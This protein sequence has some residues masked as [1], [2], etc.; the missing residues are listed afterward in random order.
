MDKTRAHSVSVERSTGEAADPTQKD[1]GRGIS[2]CLTVSELVTVLQL[3]GGI[4]STSE[5]YDD[6][7][8]L[9]SYTNDI[10]LA[11][12]AYKAV[13]QDLNLNYFAGIQI[14]YD[15][16]KEFMNEWENSDH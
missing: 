11:Y 15:W 16:R 8:I 3:H 9:R 2:Q 6:M 12:E 14:R 1:Y 5:S 7:E 10:T 4:T 13:L